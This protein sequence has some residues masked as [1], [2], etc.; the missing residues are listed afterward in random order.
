MFFDAEDSRPG[1]RLQPYRRG[2]WVFEE[3]SVRGEYGRELGIVLV[4]SQF[5]QTGKWQF[6]TTAKLILRGDLLR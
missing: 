6:D 1:R 2:L 5:D 4:K 3:M